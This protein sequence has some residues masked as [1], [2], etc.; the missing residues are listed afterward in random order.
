MKLKTNLISFG[1]TVKHKLGGLFGTIKGNTEETT[2]A[3]STSPSPP[4]SASSHPNPTRSSA[5]PPPISVNQ[6]SGG[7]VFGRPVTNE[8]HRPFHTAA[9][10]ESTSRPISPNPFLMAS[11]GL[12]RQQLDNNV[13]PFARFEGVNSTHSRPNNNIFDDI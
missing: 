1:D 3:P 9:I 8:N 12:N 4:P 11:S 5:S 13:S 7:R 10:E 2:N 6:H